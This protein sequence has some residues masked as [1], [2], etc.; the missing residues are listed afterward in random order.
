M[1]PHPQDTLHLLEKR[2]KSRFSHRIIRITSP[3]HGDRSQMAEPSTAR[4]GPARPPAA[5]A[6]KGA[7]ASGLEQEGLDVEPKWL[8]LLS[9]ALVPW[10]LWEEAGPDG[11]GDWRGAWRESIEVH[12]LASRPSFVCLPER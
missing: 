8:P 4:K 3:F 7:A 1:P 9:R 10:Q 12:C 11:E 5:D 2:V 6:A